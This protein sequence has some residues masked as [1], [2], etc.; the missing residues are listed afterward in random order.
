LTFYTVILRRN[1]IVLEGFV[2][3]FQRRVLV[4]AEKDWKAVHECS[5]IQDY[6]ALEGID[7]FRGVV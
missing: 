6:A 1:G 5:K 7:L 4:W 2:T 3:Y